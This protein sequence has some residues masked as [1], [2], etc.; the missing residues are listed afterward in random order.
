VTT[1][2][3][4][5]NEKELLVYNCPRCNMHTEQRDYG[6]CFRCIEELRV[7]MNLEKKNDVAADYIPKM[8]VVPNAIASK[9]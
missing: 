8:N 5:L 6:P 4:P 1:T 7:K 9:E 2:P 3:I